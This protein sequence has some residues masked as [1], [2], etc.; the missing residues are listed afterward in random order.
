MVPSKE[1]EEL[2]QQIGDISLRMRESQLRKRMSIVE[3]ADSPAF[4]ET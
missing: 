2:A 4:T 1:E 3:K